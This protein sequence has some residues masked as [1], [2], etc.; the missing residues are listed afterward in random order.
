M[1]FPSHKEQNYVVFHKKLMELKITM[2]SKNL[3]FSRKM[4]NFCSNMESIQ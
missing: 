2:L 4:L 3:A 1:L